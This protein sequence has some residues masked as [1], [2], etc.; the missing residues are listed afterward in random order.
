MIDFDFV[1]FSYFLNAIFLVLLVE[2]NETI[3]NFLSK[4]KWL[5]S[6]ICFVLFISTL[7]ILKFFN[8]TL[9]REQMIMFVIA[10]GFMLIRLQKKHG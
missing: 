1:A 10:F 4:N 5:P 8:C 7:S 6:L 3:N 2:K 9:S